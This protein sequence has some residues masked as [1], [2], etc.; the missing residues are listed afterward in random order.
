MTYLDYKNATY[1]I[2]MGPKKDRRV[3][4]MEVSTDSVP[5][6][7]LVDTVTDI[8]QRREERE[9]RERGGTATEA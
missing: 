6:Y 9:K 1:Y 5:K 8:Q 3:R 2:I 4:K 7:E